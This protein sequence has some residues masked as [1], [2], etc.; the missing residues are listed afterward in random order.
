MDPEAFFES[1]GMS[2]RSEDCPAQVCFLD[3][4]AKG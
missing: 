2:L 3:I 1:K 4:K